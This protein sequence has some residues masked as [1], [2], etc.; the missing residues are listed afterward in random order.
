MSESDAREIRLIGFFLL[1]VGIAIIILVIVWT[2]V[3][4]DTTYE[5]NAF[6]VLGTILFIFSGLYC[7]INNKEMARARPPYGEVLITDERFF[8]CEP[9]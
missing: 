7:I 4:G 6:T 9:F 3:T 8:F 2:A 5:Y 1:L